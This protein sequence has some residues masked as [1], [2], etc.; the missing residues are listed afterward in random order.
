MLAM[1]N[2]ASLSV[3]VTGLLFAMAGAASALPLATGDV[4]YTDGES[5]ISVDAVTGERQ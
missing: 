2:A 5:I 3:A 4:V 1:R